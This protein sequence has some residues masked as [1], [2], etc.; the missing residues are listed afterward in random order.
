MRDEAFVQKQAQQDH[1]RRPAC[2]CGYLPDDAVLLYFSF[3]AQAGYG[4][5]ASGPELQV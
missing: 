2:Y 3:V 4:D 5:R 1:H